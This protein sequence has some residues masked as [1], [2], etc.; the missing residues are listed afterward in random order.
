MLV[1][2]RFSEKNE[3]SYRPTDEGCLMRLVTTPNFCSVCIEG[4]WLEM[5]KRVSLIDNIRTGCALH[6]PGAAG[7][8]I[9]LELLSL[10]QFRDELAFISE[11]S[12]TYVI[13]W[14]KDGEP[15]PEFTNKT[16]IEV[17]NT[18]GIFIADVRFVTDEVRRDTDGYLTARAEVD[19]KEKCIVGGV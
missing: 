18:V 9:D 3:T 16:S 1:Y 13:D 7:R 10:A 14:F 6:A 19:V 15:L 5:L 8:F 17:E 2:V 4:L 11:H 12:E